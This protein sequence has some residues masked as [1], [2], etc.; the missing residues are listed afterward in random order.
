MSDLTGMLNKGL[1]TEDEYRKLMDDYMAYG[2][3]GDRFVLYFTVG[4]DGLK[5][6]AEY[7]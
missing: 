5:S 7:I 6:R 1:L 2:E 3:G 4:R